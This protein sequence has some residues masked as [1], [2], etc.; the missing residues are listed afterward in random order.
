MSAKICRF[1]CFKRPDGGSSSFDV[2]EISMEEDDTLAVAAAAAASVPKTHVGLQ[3]TATIGAGGGVMYS[4][5][6]GEKIDK[7]SNW[8]CYS[9]RSRMS[10]RMFLT[11]CVK[12]FEKQMIL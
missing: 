3:R 5:G 11:I 4:L 6:P 1:F 8:K 12:V 7:L 2:G 9:F 10:V